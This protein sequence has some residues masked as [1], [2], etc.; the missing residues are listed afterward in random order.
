[1]KGSVHVWSVLSMCQILAPA[2]ETP[3]GHVPK[4]YLLVGVGNGNT[5][6]LRWGNSLGVFALNIV[7]FQ[8]VLHCFH[9]TSSFPL[10][11]NVSGR[12]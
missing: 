2:L 11:Q 1:M 5:E 7:I 3:A 6:R 10:A 8:G 9:T 12:D 4:W